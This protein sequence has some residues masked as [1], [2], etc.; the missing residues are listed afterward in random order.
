MLT[1]L[2]SQYLELDDSTDNG[3][4]AI[5]ALQ[6]AN[7]ILA[8]AAQ[9]VDKQALKTLVQQQLDT[10]NQTLSG[11][12]HTLTQQQTNAFREQVGKCWHVWGL[13]TRAQREMLGH[14]IGELT[15]Q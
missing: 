8:Q 13:A 2:S 10:L 11:Y 1:R 5:G 7:N 15:Q 9:N 14:T 12:A 3:A 6:T 4:R